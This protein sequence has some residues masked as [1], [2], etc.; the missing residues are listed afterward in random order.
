MSPSIPKES[1]PKRKLSSNQ[2]PSRKKSKTHHRNADELPWK[3]VKRPA[4]TGINGD[5]GILELEEVEGVE[6][7][8]ETTEG[9][10]VVKFNVRV[11]VR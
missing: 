8:Y 4:E 3:T 2:L 11:Y 6:V 1:G 5:D 9:G 10:R 7:V